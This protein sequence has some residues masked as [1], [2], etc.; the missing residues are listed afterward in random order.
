MK[1]EGFTC[2]GGCGATVVLNPAD[3][4]D[5]L[6]A[7]GWYHLFTPG[8]LPTITACSSACVTEALRIH[9]AHVVDAH[10]PGLTVT[11]G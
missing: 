5:R 11:R 9:R 3:V 10:R 4:L 1:H 7:H 8:R 6:A 2:D